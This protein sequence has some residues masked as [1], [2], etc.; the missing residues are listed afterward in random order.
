LCISLSS[1]YAKQIK[2]L[3]IGNSFS[4][5]AIEH[6]LSGLVEANGDT[7]I[8][9]NMYIG[10]CSLEKHYHNAVNNYS[11]YSYRKIV[12]G[13]RT[14]TPSFNLIDAIKDEDWDYISLQQVSSL[15]G[16][17]DT[18]F[19]YI[20]KLIEFVESHSTNP[21]MDVILH[22]TWAYAS[23]ST[24]NGFKY[25][26]N[27]QLT[28][29]NAIIESSNRV[30]ERTGIDIIIPAGTA[31]QNGRTS[32]LGDT[33]CKDGYHL[34]VNYGRYTA[35]C[36]WYEKLFNKSVIGN[37]YIP[38]TVTPFQAK[39]AQ[40]AAHYAVSNPDKITP[41]DINEN[42]WN[43][44][45]PYFYPPSEYEYSFQGYRSPLQFYDG[46]LVKDKID[47]EDRRNEIRS[48]WMNMMGEWPP[49]LN[50]Q[51]FE[52][53]S[54]ENREDFTQYKV[55]FYWTPNEQTE[56]YLLVPNK[57]GKK[58]AVISVFY[59]PEP[60]IGVGEK[61]HRDFAYQLVKKGFITLSIGTS[62]T[63]KNKT[64][65]IYY[66][67]RD[68]SEIQ[69]LSLLAYA[70][71]NAF[72]ALSKV[73]DVDPERIGIVGHSYGGKWAMFASCL[74]DKFACA[75]WS[76]PGIVFDETKGS[77]VNYWEPWYL[78]YYQPPW[79]NTWDKTGENAK[80]LYPKLKQEGYDLHELH[81]LMAPRPFLVSGGSSDPLERW[82]P[83]NHTISI[84]KLLGYTHRV[85]MTNRLEHS[86]NEKSNEAI[87]SFFEWFLK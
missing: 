68:N 12:K 1:I 29:Y 56:G 45:S 44:L 34:E 67:N 78:G 48:Q 64:Y 59:E 17:Y 51:E 61:S 74:Y 16:Q 8:I 85:A 41:V 50:Q 83:L 21:S 32:S 25:Y 86:P 9:G 37:N 77:G 28:M 66:P 3:S 33:F 35:S 47:W 55:R 65:S 79:K 58:P 40:Y 81:A 22:S 42:T 4:Y 84:N 57:V 6:Y 38:H 30:A 69:P 73:N 52:I 31:I 82:I 27:D 14:E 15:S 5:D 63:T 76:D 39:V 36:V 2:L 71:A 80:G 10:G 13:N 70:A 75:A 11:V 72:E 7:I 87:Y 43:T 54:K 26:N 24:H 60:S 20:D 62:E 46:R 18:Y 49:I 19:P 53:I 23:N